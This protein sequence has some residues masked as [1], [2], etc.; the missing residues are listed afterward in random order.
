M[1]TDANFAAQKCWSF[2]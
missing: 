1:K 2:F